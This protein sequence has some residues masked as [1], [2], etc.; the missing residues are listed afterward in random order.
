M[1][2]NSFDQLDKEVLDIPKFEDVAR[3]YT[4]SDIPLVAKLKFRQ[5]RV[6]TADKLIGVIAKAA[7]FSASLTHTHR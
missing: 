1:K 4:I 2:E 5:L 3:S 7:Q 6:K